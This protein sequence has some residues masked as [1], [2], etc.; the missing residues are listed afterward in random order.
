M[1]LLFGLLPIGTGPLLYR[2]RPSARRDGEAGCCGVCGCAGCCCNGLV[3]AVG[4]DLCCCC[5]AGAAE[6]EEEEV[7][8]RG[9]P[10]PPHGNA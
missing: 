1:M 2:Q 9:G 10:E 5:T 3:K 4:V 8:G 7:L 6:E